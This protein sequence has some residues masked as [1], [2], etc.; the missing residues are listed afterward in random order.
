MSNEIP[1]Y[2]LMFSKS[3]IYDVSM[4]NCKPNFLN[5]FLQDSASRHHEVSLEP[6]EDEPAEL[7]TLDATILDTGLSDEGNESN[8]QEAERTTL[9]VENSDIQASHEENGTHEVSGM[10]EDEQETL[11]VPLGSDA[12]AAIPDPEPNNFQERAL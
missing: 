12:S 10:V 5:L 11:D 4:Y 9:P 7:L 8:V 6:S 3:A 2:L 1:K